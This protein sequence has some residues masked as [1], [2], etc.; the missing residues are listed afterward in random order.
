MVAHHA[1]NVTGLVRTQL[2]E[3]MS[4]EQLLEIIKQH[5]DEDRANPEGCFRRL[6]E[7]KLIDEDGK[8]VQRE[9]RLIFGNRD[10]EP[11]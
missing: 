11:D 10:P 3:L 5:L 1:L 4:K 6:V 7:D 2:P 8:P 9:R